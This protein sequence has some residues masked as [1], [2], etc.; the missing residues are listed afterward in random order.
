MVP[1]GTIPAW[2]IRFSFQAAI[3]VPAIIWFNKNILGVFS[4]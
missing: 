4:W 3:N 2:R 1:L